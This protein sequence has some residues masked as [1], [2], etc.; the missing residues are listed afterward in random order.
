M[1][2]HF[3]SVAWIVQSSG[4]TGQPTT[5]HECAVGLPH[6]IEAMPPVE[7]KGWVVLQYEERHRFHRPTPLL[8]KPQNL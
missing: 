2:L 8:Q 4:G 7:P 6:D 1:L 5:H 3:H